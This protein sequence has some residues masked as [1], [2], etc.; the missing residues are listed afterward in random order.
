LGHRQSTNVLRRCSSLGLVRSF[1]VLRAPSRCAAT[2]SSRTRS[3]IAAPPMRFSSLQRFPARSSILRKAGLTSP[4]RLTSSGFLNL[5]T[6]FDPLRACR[7]Y[8]MPD[9]LLGLNPSEPFSYRVAVRRLRRRSPL[10]VGPRSPPSRTLV[11]PDTARRRCRFTEPL[12]S[13]MPPK[14][15]A[16][17]SPSVS[18]R[19]KPCRSQTRRPLRGGRNHLGPTDS[20][21]LAVAEAPTKPNAPSLLPRSRPKPKAQQNRTQT[22]FSSEP[23]P[24][25][26]LSKA[27][28]LSIR[29]RDLS[30]VGS[31]VPS[32]SGPKSLPLRPPSLQEAETPLRV[33][34]CSPRREAEASFWGGRAAQLPET[35][36]LR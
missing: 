17:I 19:P 7:P 18:A 31:S 10:D 27:E 3:D 9:P 13:S 29:H 16:L 1:R 25:R 36:K 30:R 34:V 24:C 2:A 11:L 20:A 14:R 26:V 8:F 23:K 22:L 28:A 33:G 6:F 12:D 32:S 35:R 15:L 5:S 4:D 21:H